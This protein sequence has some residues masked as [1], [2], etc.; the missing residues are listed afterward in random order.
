MPND[1][2]RFSD[3]PF[4]DP[5]LSPDQVAKLDARNAALREYRKTGDPT[6][7]QEMGLFPKDDESEI[8]E[9]QQKEEHSVG[10]Y[11]QWGFDCIA[12]GYYD[13]AI[14]NFDEVI[15]IAHSLMVKACN[16]RGNASIGNGEYDRAIA[17]FDTALFLNPDD[18]DAYYN[19]GVA[20]QQKGDYDNAI[21][22][23]TKAIALDPTNA[24]AY[25]M[26]ADAYTAKAQQDHQ[27]AEELGGE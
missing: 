26:R 25:H 4:R 12:E 15:N 7:L 22:D 11:M 14:A 8:S 2:S 13:R 24:D 19:R 17:D 21:A 16:G 9:M 6:E 10:E 1:T 3:N 27:M 18:G 5:N 20:Y 23:H